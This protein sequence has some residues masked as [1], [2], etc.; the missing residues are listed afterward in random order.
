[1]LLLLVFIVVVSWLHDALSFNDYPLGGIAGFDSPRLAGGFVRQAATYC[2]DCLWLLSA[3]WGLL[4]LC[5]C[6]CVQT[7][8]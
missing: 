4:E 2:Y 3:S 7:I 5:Y 6:C 1:M 8:R